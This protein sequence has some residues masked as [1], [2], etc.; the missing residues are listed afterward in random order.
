MLWEE[1]MGRGMM[2]LGW[3]DLISRKRERERRDRVRGVWV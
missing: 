1:R 2:G 3:W